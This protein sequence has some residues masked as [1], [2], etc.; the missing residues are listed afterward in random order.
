VKTKAHTRYKL[1]NGEIVPGVTTITG[2]L[3]K[4]ALVKWSND[5]GLKGISVTSYVDDKAQIGTLAHEMILAHLSKREPDTEDY[6]KVQIDQAE[7]AFL[8]YLEWEKGHKINPE[9]IEVQAVS[10]K[11]KYGGTFD[12]YGLVDGVYELIDFK[13]GSG[14]Y[15]E[16][17]FQVAAYGN[18]IGP[19]VHR[20]RIL[21]IPRT[22]DESFREEVK[23]DVSL[24]FDGF[25][26]LLDFYNIN[27]KIKN[28]K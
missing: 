16:M 23:P 17:W 2:Q 26:K 27:R 25:C 5:I 3:N 9:L 28:D 6:S 11:L 12:F 15:P 14:I 10:E 13:T 21:N 8:S 1:S 19:I 18:L 4:P 7:N 22:E 24:Y 20:Y